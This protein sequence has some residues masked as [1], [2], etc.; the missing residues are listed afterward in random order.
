VGL[1]RTEL[2]GEIKQVTMVE[3]LE[4]HHKNLLLAGALLMK[5]SNK[6]APRA[7]HIYVTPDLKWLVWK[8]PKEPVDPKQRMKTIKLRSVERGRATPQLQRKKLLG[9]FFAKEECAFAI[10]GRER[11]VDLEANSEAER[12]A[13]APPAS[14]PLRFR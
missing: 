12:Y 13:A 11:S 5:H 8:D 6:A 1:D 2:F 4:K 9:G 14:L 10:L 7:R 3:E